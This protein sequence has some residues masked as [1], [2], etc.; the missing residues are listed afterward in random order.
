MPVPIICLDENVCQFAERFRQSSLKPQYQ[1]F[2]IVL[3]GL[4]HCEGRRTSSGLLRQIGARTELGRAEPLSLASALGSCS[5]GERWPRHF[6]EEM[7]PQVEAEQQRQRQEQPKRRGRPKL[8]VVTGYL[9]GDDSTIRNA[10][11]RRWKDWVGITR[12]RRQ[13]HA[14]P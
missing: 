14:R 6:R 1:Y 12:R 5:G 13:T 3:L 8:P 2:V 7:Q 4:M 9:I 11:A 10:R